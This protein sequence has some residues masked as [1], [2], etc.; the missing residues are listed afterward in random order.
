VLVEDTCPGA[1]NSTIYQNITLP[2][3]VDNVNEAPLHTGPS[4]V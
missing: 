3:M 4:T 2:V 1:I